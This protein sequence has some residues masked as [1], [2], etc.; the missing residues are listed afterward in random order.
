[1]NH[2]TRQWVCS[3]CHGHGPVWSFH[4]HRSDC[5]QEFAQAPEQCPLCAAHAIAVVPISAP[6]SSEAD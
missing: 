2:P 5:I 3:E 6:V 4:V 1:M